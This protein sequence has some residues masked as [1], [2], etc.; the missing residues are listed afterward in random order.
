MTGPGLKVVT[1]FCPDCLKE[2]VCRVLVTPEGE[3]HIISGPEEHRRI[4]QGAKQ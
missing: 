2:V 1:A 4:C 3:A